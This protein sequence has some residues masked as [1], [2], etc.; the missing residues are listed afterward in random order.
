MAAAPVISLDGTTILIGGFPV[1]RT[2]ARG[3][4]GELHLATDP[5]TRL[6]IALKTVRFQAGEL[7]RDRFLRESAAAARLQHPN[8][9]STY[10][11][12]IDGVEASLCGWIAMEWVSGSDLNRY[13]SPPRLLPEPLLLEIGAS[14]AD[15]LFHAHGQGVVHRDIKPSNVLLNLATGT[16]KITDFGCAHL[17]D[18]ERSRSG[19]LIGTPVYMAP[20]QLAG[21]AVDGRTD[22]YALGVLMYQLLTGR[23][24]FDYPSM[25]QTL[26]AI[27]TEPAPDLLILRPELPRPLGDLLQALMAKRPEQRPDDGQQVAALLR[28]LGTNFYAAAPRTAVGQADNN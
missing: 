8:I 9:V 5:A 27:A 17:S 13:A 19:L 1:V 22:L 25:G 16:V 6:P 24:P 7:S 14:I 18:S 12:G 2:F 20:E 15:G 23:L 21:Q 4:M 10:A 3:A 26:A 11:A 28:Q